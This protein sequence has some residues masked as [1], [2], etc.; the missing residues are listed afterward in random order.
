MK[1]LQLARCPCWQFESPC[2]LRSA[3]WRWRRHVSPRGREVTQVMVNFANAKEFPVHHSTQTEPVKVN[4][5]DF[6]SLFSYSTSTVRPSCW[7]LVSAWFEPFPV[8]AFCLPTPLLRPRNK[9]RSSWKVH[10]NVKWSMRNGDNGDMNSNTL[11]RESRLVNPLLGTPL[12]AY[13]LL[14]CS[15]TY[16]LLRGYSSYSSLKIHWT[17][18]LRRS[19]LVF[20]YLTSS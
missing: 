18:V 3:S 4:R 11:H 1:L 6:E 5:F 7:T 8:V 13:N 14:L 2:S 19:F 20:S 15:W 16:F 10:N 17:W 9:H 12:K